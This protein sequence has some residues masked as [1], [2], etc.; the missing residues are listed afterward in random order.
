MPLGMSGRTREGSSSSAT[1]PTGT[2]TVTPTRSE[3]TS[4][5]TERSA[6]EGSERSGTP[7]SRSHSRSPHRHR[8]HGHRRRSRFRFKHKER[9]F[10]AAVCSMVVIVVL[11][12]AMAEPNWFDVRGGG[13]R[14]TDNKAV[15]T[16][17][18]Y[19]FFYLGHFEVLN[20]HAE[21]IAA[22]KTNSDTKDAKPNAKSSN[23]AY[24]YSQTA[25]DCK[26]VVYPN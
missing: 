11:C 13:C 25:A 19:Q 18:V 8:H 2:G 21:K 9:N 3:R 14:D 22:A 5:S 20:G 26:F 17:G 12:T 10:L 6:R 15:H 24:H 16:M 7:T 1:L 4:T 23:Q